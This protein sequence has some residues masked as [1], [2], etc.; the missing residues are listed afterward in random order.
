MLF[1]SSE[2]YQ[3][4]L[5]PHPTGIPITKLLAF[6]QSFWSYRPPPPG[7]STPFCWGEGEY[8]YILEL[9]IVC[10]ELLFH[11][12]KQITNIFFHFYSLEDLCYVAERSKICLTYIV[13]MSTSVSLPFSSWRDR[14][15]ER[16]NK[17]A[18]GEHKWWDM[19]GG[20]R[21][22]RRRSRRG[23]PPLH[24]CLF[25]LHAFTVSFPSC[26]FR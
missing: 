26:A 5:R 10:F 19:G 2:Q 24:C 14:I 21:K 16:A 20:V 15:S 8:K 3:D 4:F 17:R 1:C 22:L 9:H 25:F 7:N 23:A 11:E 6:L 12:S 18:W 13:S